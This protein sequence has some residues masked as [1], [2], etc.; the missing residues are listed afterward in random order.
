MVLASTLNRSR[1]IDSSDS[2]NFSAYIFP[3]ATV[4]L[5]FSVNIFTTLA[6]ISTR[7]F[8]VEL[9]R[10]GWRAIS[11]VEQI[12]LCNLWSSSV[13]YYC[14]V[15]LGNVHGFKLSEVQLNWANLT[16]W[17]L[18]YPTFC[19]SRPSIIWCIRN[20]WCITTAY[21]EIYSH[22][23]LRRLRYNFTLCCKFNQS[24]VFRHLRR[25]KKET[26]ASKMSKTGFRCGE[27]AEMPGKI[28]IRTAGDPNRDKAVCAR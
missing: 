13:R 8:V 28:P 21:R 14:I 1:A 24:T 12:S 19:Y 17:S 27:M 16:L 11:S 6:S 23:L 10:I 7:K 2:I 5:F 3:L 18:D 26:T 22:V 25:G 15:S 9:S 4:N 20:R